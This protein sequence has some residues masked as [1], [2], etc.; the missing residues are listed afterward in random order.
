[1]SELRP[2]HAPRAAGTRVQSVV[3]PGGIEAWLVEEHAVPLLAV[4][5]AFLGGTSQ[6]PAD[7][8]GVGY[9]LSGLLDEGAGSYSAEAFQER[10]ET[11]AVEMSFSA[12]KTAFTGSMRTLLK[13]R[14]AAFDLLR[15]ALTEARLE[16]EAI[17][18]VR[19][20]VSAGLRREINEPNAVSSRAWFTA[21]YPGH[22]YGRPDR[23]TLETIDRID[24]NALTAYRSK[25]LA[26]SNLRVAVV[27]AIDAAT[28]APLLDK[29]FGDLPAVAAVEA[30]P[31]VV[32]QGT[33]HH[34]VLDLDI[35]QSTVRFGAPG[36]LRHDPDFITASIVNHILGGGAFTSRL[37]QEVRERRGLAYSVSSSLVTYPGTGIFIGGTATKN[38]RAKESIDIIAEEIRRLAAE[39]PSVEE[40][41]KAK[42]F[43]IGSYALRFDTS[44]KIAA[45][46]VQNQIEDL[47][48]DYVNRRNDL[49]A[50]VTHEDTVRVA[51]RMF[52]PGGLLVTVAGRPVG[53]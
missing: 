35:P 40:V 29:V 3:S 21:A 48:I 4:E 33:G 53:L 9:V 26:R 50:A 27:G 14:D 38:E 25:V 24:L 31:A 51:E 16:A 45:Q 52:K 18:R 2:D 41:T 1:M 34:H 43:L 22:P 47:G 30:V 37:W 11:L 28:L 5:I 32:A 44:S 19:S 7:N 20:Q 15:L 13:H 6:D 42:Q 23:G 39:G 12:G 46:L 49:F 10:L 17:D 36:L 8:P